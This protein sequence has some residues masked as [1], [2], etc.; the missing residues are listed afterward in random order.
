MKQ[1]RSILLALL[2]GLLLALPALADEIYEPEDSFYQSHARECEH[3]ERF[4]VVTGAG[5][6][7]AEA[8]GQKSVGSCAAGET[9]YAEYIWRSEK[10][11]ST[12]GLVNFRNAEGYWD[13][14][15]VLLDGMEIVPDGR[16]FN[17]QYGGEVYT[18]ED[19]PEIK[20]WE[21]G[22]YL[23]TYPGAAEPDAVLDTF[24]DP[25]HFY[26]ADLILTFRTLYDDPEG[27]TWGRIDY[28]RGWQD[29]WV[30]LSDPENPDLPGSGLAAGT[31]PA[32]S[33]KE[34]GFPW[35]AVGLAGGAVIAAGALLLALRKRNGKKA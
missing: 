13:E 30:C 26:D 19:A 5:A 28:W 2:L 3:A 12:W 17:A 7:V 9:I 16:E 35:L 1:G 18:S 11:G 32:G 29:R 8:P 27:R 14:G 10:S 20:L 4:Y 21:T 24:V 31:V 33:G 22:P 25:E 15:W 6:D 34:A 23:W